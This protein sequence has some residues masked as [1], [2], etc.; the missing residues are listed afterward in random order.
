MKT[1][2]GFFGSLLSSVASI[3]GQHQQNQNVNKQ[4]AAQSIENQKMREY[5]L[6]LAKQ[7]NEWNKQ[8]WQMENRYNSPVAQIQRMRAAG[9]NPDMMYGGGVSGN[10]SAS[11]PDMTS[12]SPASPVDWSSLSNKQTI[13]STM[14]QVL[15]N[16][17]T[18]A[19]I[20]NINAD[21]KKQG[22]ETDILET[23]SAFTEAYQ[24]GVLATQ[25]MDIQVKQSTIE[26]N[27]EQ[28]KK[29]QA[30]VR[31]LDQQTAKINNEI[32]KIRAEI[33][34]LDADTAYK[35]LK[36]ELDKKLNDAT[37]KKIVA[38]TG[39]TYQ[40]IKSLSEQLPYI[41]TQFE[42]AHTISLS[43]Q[44][45]LSIEN[46]KIKFDAFLHGPDGW[47]KEYNVWDNLLH[48]L[49]R[50]MDAAFAPAVSIFK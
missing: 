22:V 20:E 40:Q 25:N 27:A 36:S 6:K 5:N 18:Q 3:W 11:S 38:D 41:I 49:T 15:Q 19:Q 48:G 37:I 46:G 10:L 4:L 12:G 45:R 23:E 16:E 31:N 7:Q 32:N 8:Q 28:V 39:L 33:S 9:L 1:K 43:N 21:T 50:I 13:G 42:D 34:N 29:I 35:K 30:D 17:M 47:N 24:K 2:K 14:Q 44:E 26:L